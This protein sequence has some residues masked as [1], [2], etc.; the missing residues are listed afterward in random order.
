MR[1]VAIGRRTMNERSFIVKF[2]EKGPAG[3]VDRRRVTLGDH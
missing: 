3:I 1:F 2:T